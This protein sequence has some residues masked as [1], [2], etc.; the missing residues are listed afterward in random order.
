MSLPDSAPSVPVEI[1]AGRASRALLRQLV[2]GA[3]LG[4]VLKFG[5]VGLAFLMLLM[6]ARRMDSDAY[7][8]FA[9]AFSVATIAGFV[10]TLG[11]HVAILRFWSSL[12]EAHGR[13][14][15]SAA[16]RF[17][18][19]LTFAGATLIA[20]GLTLAGTLAPQLSLFG[21]TELTIALTGAM[22][23]A[24]ALSET[25][26]AGLRARGSIVFALAPREIVW[27]LAVIAGAFAIPAPLGADTALTVIAVALIA[28]T[29]PQLAVLVREA[30]A[31]PRSPAPTED[32]RA[33]RRSVLD[34]WGGGAVGPLTAHV[35]TILVATLLG[36]AA[37]GAYFAADR[38]AKLLSIALIGVNQIVGPMIARSWRGGRIDEVSFLVFA[39]SV[40]A[41]AVAV[42]GFLVY[43]LFGRYALSLFNPAYAEALPILLIL[44]VGQL[45]NTVCGP[46]NFLLN[47]AGRERD[48]L[49]IMT[50]WGIAAIAGIW[51]G[52][53]EFGVLGAATAS[54]LAM[55]GWNITA[56][57][58]AQIRLGV[59]PLQGAL[60]Y[61]SKSD[62]GQR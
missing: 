58:T 30:L 29:A 54:T 11:Q 32:A 61:L 15:A 42:A 8:V 26:V 9:A 52:A 2:S 5:G 18:L 41:F 24:F 49:V 48:Y 7:G 62:R 47:M 1:G 51:I 13:A 17:S 23:G 60:R 31:A 46:N 36:P 38:I 20:G 14:A 35:G 50:V 22:A 6:L 40:I 39:G 21:G 19:S 28:V 37:A 45:V 44:S 53:S 56:V 16:L 59:N 33:L 27:R 25:A 55:T 57:A 12:D 4:A 34:F 3:A 43:L 10:A